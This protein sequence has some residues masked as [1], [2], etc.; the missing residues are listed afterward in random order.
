MAGGLLA[1]LEE[2]PVGI[3]RVPEI[4]VNGAFGVKWMGDTLVTSIKTT[5]LANKEVM[6]HIFGDVLKR[7]IVGEARFT[8]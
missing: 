3:E 7:Q 4:L 5:N 1:R 6:Q 8:F 2:P